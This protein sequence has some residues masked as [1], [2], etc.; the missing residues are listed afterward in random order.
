METETELSTG[1]S[2]IPI[3]R[4]WDETASPLSHG[5]IGREGGVGAG[6]FAS[7]N[8]SYWVNDDARTVDANW[9]RLRG[10]VPELKSVARVNQV[11]NNIVHVVTRENASSRPKADGIVTAEPGLM[12]GIFTADCVPILMIDPKQKLAGALHA[13]WR[14]VLA[15]IV[16]NGVRAMTSL[17]A[18][19]DD[20]RA[21]TGPSIGPCCFEVDAALAE[22]FA[23]EIE[24]SERHARLG[25][26]DKAYLDLR[27]IVKDQLLGAGLTGANITAVGPCTR[28]ASDRFFSRRAAGGNITGLQMSF[29]GFPR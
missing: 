27:A 12:I 13:G 3:L 2:V 16:E 25:R 19:I 23:S 21:A 10:Q 24:G 6:P 20:L 14:G 9:E 18:H 7:L 28:C 15:G 11:H 1:A 5:F 26:P 8:L 17:G 4:A 22:R 29:A